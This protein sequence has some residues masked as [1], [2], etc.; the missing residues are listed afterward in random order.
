MFGFNYS[1]QTKTDFVYFNLCYHAP[2]KWA[3]RR[4]SKN[5]LQIYDGK[6]ELDRGCRPEV[7]FSFVKYQN[8]FLEVVINSVLRPLYKQKTSQ[9]LSKKLLGRAKE[10]VMFASP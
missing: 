8:R 7:I 9:R 10:Q 6:G 1:I 2:V 5:I 4:P 3:M